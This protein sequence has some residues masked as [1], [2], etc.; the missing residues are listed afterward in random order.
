MV[1]DARLPKGVTRD[2]V[3]I[4]LLEDVL[5]Q[6]SEGAQQIFSGLSEEDGACRR[7]LRRED[8]RDRSSEK[9]R[10]SGVGLEE[11]F[12]F[13]A[14]VMEELSRVGAGAK[15]TISSSQDVR[16]SQEEAE[17]ELLLD[18]RRILEKNQHEVRSEVFAKSFG[19]VMSLSGGPLA[20]Q[21]KPSEITSN[22]DAARTFSLEN[23]TAGS[24]EV[25]RERLQDIIASVE[26]KEF[27]LDG[28]KLSRSDARRKAQA[29]AQL[30]L[31]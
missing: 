20:A 4:L 18:L 16:P 3:L 21:G 6:G 12:E 15:S 25:E 19:N 2:D 14:N 7:F 28:G 9:C 26:R 29:E 31:L 23:D 24:V 22:A 5:L 13:F 27:L 1:T 8:E 17:G 30:K 10:L 11:F